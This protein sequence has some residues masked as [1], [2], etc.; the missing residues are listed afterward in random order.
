MRLTPTELARFG[1]LVLV[2]LQAVCVE[3]AGVEPT[4]PRGPQCIRHLD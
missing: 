2:P 1:V 3:G 4:V